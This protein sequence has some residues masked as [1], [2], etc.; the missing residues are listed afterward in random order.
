MQ[1]AMEFGERK[2]VGEVGE[3]TERFDRFLGMIR[4]RRE[5]KYRRQRE[6]DG[7]SMVVAFIVCIWLC[8]L[9]GF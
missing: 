3:M 7:V 6:R 5:R 9:A 8:Y 4:E 2:K 1:K